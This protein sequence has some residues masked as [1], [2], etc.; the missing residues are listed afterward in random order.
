MA[1]MGGIILGIGYISLYR[2]LDKDNI[3]YSY[4]S[5]LFPLDILSA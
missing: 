1:G 3:G 5:R 4:T 2:G